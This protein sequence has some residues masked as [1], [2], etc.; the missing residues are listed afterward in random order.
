M[1]LYKIGIIIKQLRKQKA[2]SQKQLAAG[3]CSTEYISKIENEIK[4]PSPEMSSK[5]LHRLGVNPDMFFTNLSTTD[6]DI[7]NEHCFEMDRLIRA[8]KFEEARSYIRTLEKTFSFYASGEPLQYL[9]GKEAHILANLDKKFDESYELAYQSI[10]LTKEDFTVERMED[11]TFFSVNELWSMLYM[12]LAIYWKQ[13]HFLTG[14]D[15]SSAINLVAI[16]LSHLE[17]GYHHP[18]LIDNL[19]TSCICFQSRFLYSANRV[20]EAMDV[21]DKGLEF[22]LSRYNHTIEIL[23]KIMMNRAACA[24]VCY[25]D[26]EKEQFYD[27]GKMLLQLANNDETLHRYLDLERDVLLMAIK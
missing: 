13:K 6:N 26:K 14:E 11:Y 17:R 27:I 4:T 10:L 25:R 2:F 20:Q 9:M 12:A 23:G 5:L 15:I 19:Y 18:S 7:Y 22:I 1:S 24:G 21:T 8:S 16:I 3:I